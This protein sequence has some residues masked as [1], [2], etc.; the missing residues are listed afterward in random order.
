[1]LVSPAPRLRTIALAILVAALIPLRAEET[2]LTQDTGFAV[3]YQDLAKLR[4]TARMMHVT[5]HP[6]D[7][8]GA[9]L[10][11]ESRGKGATVLLQSMNRGEGGQNRF[12]N[13]LFDELGILRTLE[14]LAADQYYGVEQRFTR[15]VDFGFSKNA[16]ETFDKWGG[17]DIA[18]SD[19]VRVIRTFRPDVLTTRFNGTPR[20]GHG[21]HEASGVLTKEAFRA[22]A[23][24]NRFP[25]QIKEGLLPW[26]AKKLYVGARANEDWTLRLNT[27]AYSP[28]LGMAYAQFSLEGLAHQ[29]SQGTGGLRVPPGDRF[30]YYKLIDSVL[31]AGLPPAGTHEQDFYDGIDTSLPAL[32]SRLG[33]EEPKT[34][35]L[36]PALVEL[37]HDAQQAIAAFTPADPSRA[38]APLLAGVK[39]LQGLISQV[40]GSSLAN[41]TKLEMLAHLRTKL[42]QFET[43][44]NDAMGV[45][46]VA[47]VDTPP[48][49]AQGGFFRM[50]QTFLMAVPGQTFTAT[51]HLYNRGQ[52]RIDAEDISLDLPPGWQAETVSQKRVPIEPNGE[53]AA[54][55]KITVPDDARYTRPYFHRTDPQI[56]NAYHIDEPQ[57]ATLPFPPFPAYV[58]ATYNVG[59]NSSET[60]AVVQVK[61]VDPLYGQQARPLPVGPPLALEV[62][63]PTQVV[64]TGL[65][66]SAHVRVGVRNNVINGA[67][68]TLRLDVPQGWKVE[69]PS[70]AA[71]FV[72]N[73][74][75]SSFDFTVTPGTMREQRYE[76][77]AVLDYNGKSSNDGYHVVTRHDL[78]TYYYYHPASQQV[79]AVAVKVAKGLRVGYIMGAGDDIP[80][81]LKQ[82]GVDVQMISS[83]E[84]ASGDLGR[85]DTILLGIRCYDVRTDVREHNKRLL[86][87][88]SRGGT[89]IV[90]YEHDTGPF[91]AGHYTPYP[92]TMAN[93]RVT[94]EESPVEIL[95][96]ADKVFNSPNKITQNDF[97]GW[98]QERGLSFMS[99]WDAHYK[100]LLSS[101][102]PGEQPS[103]GGLLVA[104]YGKGTYIYT[105][106]AFFRQVPAGV[107][108][109]IRLFVNL[110]SVGAKP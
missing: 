13:E 108:G 20:D 100:P 75:Y 12:G 4:T 41:A 32:A 89:L 50:E 105:G 78:G 49:A 79:S 110:L 15:V 82:I 9:V 40:E 74:E 21:N 81:V 26:Q 22:A 85:Y 44:A 45:M 72:S 27:G 76:V 19:I 29:I 43:T 34:A 98:V 91:N 6:D 10:T 83:A 70:Q 63:P 57:Y 71:N 48:T 35:F 90:Q 2:R 62:E 92:A 93:E 99:Q 96:P 73:G 8:D 95:D 88:V 59:S 53:A 30:A 104:Q 84:L 5:A 80:P 66:G 38:A 101:H 69:P 67:K 55:F 65:G 11:L 23:D 52:Q 97:N 86:D 77:K 31:P 61:Y 94:V 14:L 102:D 60:R 37:D 28:A 36:R 64:A 109:A 25:E 56:E 3:V 107:P 54:Q 47:A 1:M 51:A 46:L 68:G 39:L 87:Y 106:Y 24:P 7:E 16:Q 17:H 33:S 58:H 103:K 18:L 42:E